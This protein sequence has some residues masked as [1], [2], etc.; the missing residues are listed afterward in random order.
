MS[1][2]SLMPRLF[3]LFPV[4]S[5]LPSVH[6]PQHD[7]ADVVRVRRVLTRIILGH[8]VQLLDVI[9]A[10]PLHDILKVVPA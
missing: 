4:L 3:V 9:E 2:S 7:G 6:V 1:L 10:V 5:S 8:E